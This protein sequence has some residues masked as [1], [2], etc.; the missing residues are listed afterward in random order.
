MRN[1]ARTLSPL[2]LL[3]LAACGGGTTSNFA[4]TT[5]SKARL[6]PGSE[7]HINTSSSSS[8]QFPS[9]TGLKNGGYVVTWESLEGSPQGYVVYGQ[10]YDSLG[11]T[12]GDEFQIATSTASNVHYPSV[13]GLNDG[14]YVATWT[15]EVQ[16]GD[17][18]GQR[19]DSLDNTVGAEFQ[20]NTSTALKQSISSVTGLKDGGFV[21]T[22]TSEVQDVEIYSNGF[23]APTTEGHRFF[24]QRY[25]SLGNSA[26]SEL[27]INTFTTLG[28]YESSVTGLNDGG[29]VITWTTSGQDGS[30]LGIYGQRYDSLGNMVGAE[31]QI[32]TYT[33]S[34]QSDSSVTGLKDGGFVVTWTSKHQDG[35]QSGIYGQ[36]YDSMGSTVGLEFLINTSTAHSQYDSFVTGLNDGSFVVTWTHSESLDGSGSTVRGQHYDSLGNMLG[37]EFLINTS[38]PYSH[39]ES[40][41]ASLE[42]GSFVVAS[43]Y[44]NADLN[45]FPWETGI[46]GQHFDIA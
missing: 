10:R 8:G 31:F 39:Y 46:L 34:N 25:D 2:S 36:R 17:I 40:S 6:V 14:G 41:V 18:H 15:S 22:W 38:A 32:N 42:D 30:F 3:A 33:A 35:D 7:F 29:F 13:T 11:N 20:I 44:I 45:D 1:V 12:A 26:G 16:D 21:V 24:G 23:H 5:V 9:V 4:S 27:L 28:Q 37:S 43:A 19:Y